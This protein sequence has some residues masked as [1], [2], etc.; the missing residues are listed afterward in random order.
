[1]LVE[2]HPYNTG[3]DDERFNAFVSF[4]DY[5]VQQNARFVTVAGLVEW[6]QANADG[7]VPCAED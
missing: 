5:A 2:V 4:L 1:L 3:A 7:C 6:S